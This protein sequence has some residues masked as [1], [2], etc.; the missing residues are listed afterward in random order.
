VWAFDET[1]REVWNFKTHIDSAFFSG[2]RLEAP[3][4]TDPGPPYN[5]RGVYSIAVG[6]FRKDG[7]EQVAVGRPCTVE[8]HRLDGSLIRRIPTRWGT[9]TSLALLENTNVAGR[10]RMLLA[11]KANAGIP[12]L[13]SVDSLFDTVSD[14]LFGDLPPRYIDMHAWMQRGTRHLFV[15]DV[16]RDGR[17][18][19]IYTLSGHWNELR[20]YDGVTGKPRWVRYLGPDKGGMPFMSAAALIDLDGGGRK[21]VVVG[22]K[23]GWVLAFDA[24]GRTVLSKHFGAPVT[25]IAGRP[26]WGALAVGTADGTVRLVGPD[27]TIR[28]QGKLKGVPADIVALPGH[29]VIG[30]SLGTVR[31]YD[32]P[33]TATR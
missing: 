15:E 20:L 4:F 16:D 27:G 7:T 24:Q 32:V 5:M 14:D 33:R 18:E 17:P 2:D 21:D 13:S 9:N 8:F 3:W 11:A 31:R 19:V 28:L 26:E 25:V 22:T 29:L 12:R 6:D 30:D 10:K 23:T 1:A